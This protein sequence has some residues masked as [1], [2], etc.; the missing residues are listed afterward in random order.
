MTILFVAADADLKSVYSAA[1]REAGYAVTDSPQSP[2]WDLLLSDGQFL[3]Q[4][5]SKPFIFLG[6]PDDGS[7]LHPT[8]CVDY[9]NST[10]GDLVSLI[11]RI[12]GT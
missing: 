8:A 4:D 10:P 3:P 11:S 2:G 6:S 5:S 9:L 1:L 12:L 7:N